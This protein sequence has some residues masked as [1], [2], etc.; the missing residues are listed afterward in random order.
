MPPTMAVVNPASRIASPK[1]S[2]GPI[3]PWKW[4]GASSQPSRSAIVAWTSG[5]LDQRLVSR[6]NSRSAQRSPC[7]RAPRAPRARAAGPDRRRRWPRSRRYLLRSRLAGLGRLDRQDLVQSAAVARLAREACR[8]ERQGALER[9]LGPIT[10]EPR[11]RTFMSSCSTPWWAEYV[12][13]QTAART[14]RILFAATDAPTPEPQIEDA[15]L[16]L[17]VADRP[18]EPLGE[19]G[20]VVR[21]VRA[22]AAEVDE[23][24][25]EVRRGE[26]ARASS[27]LERRSG[28]IGGE[29][30]AHRLRPAGQC[31][32]RRR[33][34]GRGPDRPAAG[35]PAGGRVDRR[36]RG[37]G[38]R[39]A[40]P[41]GRRRRRDRR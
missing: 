4:P 24:V 19:V 11:V 23:L 26:P 15:P 22:V 32:A 2:S 3:S 35:R 40:R 17:A 21:R 10:R 37:R 8:E 38:A 25:A 1:A 16:G 31:R 6:S 13:W 28:V 27:V 34:R 39:R 9:R 29:R 5:S 12:S 7:G 20:V 30:D 14:P 41:A 33:R 36:D 18:A